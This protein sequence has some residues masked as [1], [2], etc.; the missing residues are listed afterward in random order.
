VVKLIENSKVTF[1]DS[2]ACVRLLY[3]LFW[4]ESI[5]ASFCVDIGN[6]VSV[7][8]QTRKKRVS[9]VFR[10]NVPRK[11]KRRKVSFIVKESEKRYFFSPVCRKEG[12]KN[13]QKVTF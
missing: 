4:H 8:P 1:A 13:R 10:G 9:I 6:L 3:N 2:F 7:A 5:G 12:G 11:Q